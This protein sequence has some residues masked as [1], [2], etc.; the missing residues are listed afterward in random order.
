[1]NQ[2]EFD[3]VIEV[4]AEI[5]NWL[6]DVTEIIKAIDELIDMHTA[7]LEGKPVETTPKLEDIKKAFPNQL[8]DKIEVTE[9]E[10]MIFIKP[11]KFLGSKLFASLA[12]VCKQLGGEYISMGR[13]SHFRIVK[14][15]KEEET[16]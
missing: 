1:M 2:K 14:T 8:L 16:R 9:S 7:K 11:K 5:R 15:P 6:E 3:K 13:D 4:L 10:G 12:E